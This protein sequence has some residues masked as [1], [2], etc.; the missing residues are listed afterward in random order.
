MGQGGE[1]TEAG[2]ARSSPSSA[3]LDLSP[4][5]PRPV[6]AAVTSTGLLPSAWAGGVARRRTRKRALPPQSRS[7]P[8]VDR[9]V[10]A[11]ASPEEG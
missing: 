9:R 1:R 4:L 3:R 6:G 11:E 8:A 7:L 10:A 5:P 2:A